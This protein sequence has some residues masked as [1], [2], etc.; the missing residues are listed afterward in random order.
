M[1]YQQWTNH[2]KDDSDKEEFTKAIYGSKRILNRLRDLLQEEENSLEASELSAASFDKPNWAYKQA[3]KN[4]YRSCLNVLKKL[5][6]LDKQ[7][8]TDG[9]NPVRR[10]RNRVNS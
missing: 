3:Y 10:T 4:G 2:I 9:P 6:D 8:T 1:L 7:E 5:I